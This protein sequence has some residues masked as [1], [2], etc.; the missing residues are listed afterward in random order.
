MAILIKDESAIKKIA[1]A[2]NIIYEIFR[3]IKKMDLR[4]MMT[5]ELNDKID[6]L[7]RAHN[8]IPA[9]LNYQGFP[10]SCCISLNDEVVHG[11]PDD[12]KIKDGDLVKIDVGVTYKDY[13]ADAA[14]TFVVDEIP[15]D[16]NKLVTITKQA[17]KNGIEKARSGNKISDISQA[18]QETVESNGFSVVRELTGHGV[19]ERLHEE[20]MIP[21]FVCDGPDVV[22][23]PGMV[24]AIEPMVNMGDYEVV[25][26]KNGW[27]I[28]TKD[29]SP[30]CHFEDT[31]AILEKGILNLTR[32]V[33]D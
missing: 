4:G 7:I 10:K 27:T 3:T 2:G 14:R 8:A 32:T 25:T 24:L 20:P 9:F 22:I 17:L 23:K 29:G 33:E 30:S 28:M 13:I 18:I 26:A 12:R 5:I 1:A 16:I 6:K 31:I 19:G 21:N 11:I 15:T